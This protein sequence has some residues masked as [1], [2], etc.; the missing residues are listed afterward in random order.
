MI[1]VII[2]AKNEAVTLWFTVH[3]IRMEMERDPVEPWEIVVVDNVSTDSTKAFLEDWAIK[4]WV[5]R[6][7]AHADISGPGPVRN[8]GAT[9]AQGEILVFMDAHVLPSPG[10]FRQIRHTMHQEIWDKVGS[11]HYPIGWNGFDRGAFSTNYELR[12][13]RDF[14][15]DNRTGNYR[16]LTEIGAHGHGCVAMRRDH[17][18]EVGGYHPGQ[19]GYGGDESYM[20]LKFAMFGFHNYS[21][22]S[23]YYLHCSQRHMNYTWNNQDVIRNHM[24]SAYT[25]GGLP[26]L[27]KVYAYQL[28][29]GYVPEHELT[30]A[31]EMALS[32]GRADRDWIAAHARHTL[33]EVLADFKTRGVPH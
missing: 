21:D 28:A 7:E 12:L 2:P 6:V 32:A 5:R 30:P 33:D 23:G 31:R 19:A 22:P 4:P 9:A 18:I 1:S 27:E 20:D 13:E 16:T 3:A 26:W 17:F 15:G 24:I 10:F 29:K 8:V 14:W 11:L 25:L